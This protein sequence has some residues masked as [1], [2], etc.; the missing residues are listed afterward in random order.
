MKVWSLVRSNGG[1]VTIFFHS[2]PLIGLINGGDYLWASITAR[3]KD[4]PSPVSI[5]I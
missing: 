1:Y 4:V 3:V 5:G 2:V